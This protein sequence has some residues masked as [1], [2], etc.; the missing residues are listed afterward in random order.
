MRIRKKATGAL[1]LPKE[2][3]L[4]LPLLTA[5][6]REELAIENYKSLLSFSETCIRLH[7]SVGQLEIT[8]QRLQLKHITTEHIIITGAVAAIAWE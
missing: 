3:V 2:I 8:G 1:S 4:D 5:M 7:T 6:G